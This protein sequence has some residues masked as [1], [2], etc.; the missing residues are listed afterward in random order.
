MVLKKYKDVL[1]IFIALL[2]LLIE[3]IQLNINIP[4]YIENDIPLKSKLFFSK[5]ESEID[6]QSVDNKIIDRRYKMLNK[7]TLTYKMPAKNLKENYFFEFENVFDKKDYINLDS[8]PINNEKYGEVL[9]GYSYYHLDNSFTK[10]KALIKVK[11]VLPDNAEEV[12]T[13][14]FQKCELIKYNTDKGKFIV[15]LG[16][17]KILSEESPY[18]RLLYNYDEDKI[19]LIKYFKEIK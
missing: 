4:K 10:D 15:I 16:Y 12:Y 17:K 2:I 9:L 18:P 3:G 14:K 5:S 1:I 6:T 11:S 19:Q 8:K 13:N 7:N